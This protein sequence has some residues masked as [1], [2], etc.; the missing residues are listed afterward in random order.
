M[1]PPLPPQGREAFPLY[2]IKG[3]ADLFVDAC[4][5]NEA[6]QLLFLSVFGRD[7]SIQQLLASFALGAKENGITQ[8]KLHVHGAADELVL[9]GDA[10]RLEKL[11]GR[12]PRQNLF[13]NL[14]HAWIFDPALVVPDRAN[15][16]VWRLFGESRNPHSPEQR[17]RFTAEL[18]ATLRQLMPVPLLEHWRE[19][20]LREAAEHVAWFEHFGPG[21]IGRVTGYKLEL[22]E[23]F[24]ATVSTLVREGELTLTPTMH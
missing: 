21:P 19:P 11:T 5:R 14:T 6:G 24:L 12:L 8:F 23:A 3:R 17:E 4:A 2:R 13:G 20:V 18:W 9:I 22:P 10:S 16:L 7:T 1:H 15:R